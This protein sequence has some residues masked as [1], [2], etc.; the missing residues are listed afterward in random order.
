M[1]GNKFIL[2][3]ILINV[4]ILLSKG[5]LGL[6]RMASVLDLLIYDLN[7]SIIRIE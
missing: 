7:A 5:V 6:V 2:N 3:K 4:N 1:W